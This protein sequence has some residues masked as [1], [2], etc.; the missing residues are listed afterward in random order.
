MERKNHPLTEFSRIED[1]V[2][3]TLDRALSGSFFSDRLNQ[4]KIEK[5][6]PTCDIIDQGNYL[7]LRAE[8]P[9][10]KKENLKISV[11]ETSISLKGELLQN[12]ETEGEIYYRSERT[13]GSFSR[14][15]DLPIEVNP[16]Q[17]DAALNE[18]ILEVKLPKKKSSKAKKVEIEI[19]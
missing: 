18:G 13:Y 12:K 1:V 4:C 15:I 6:I 11:D 17:V 10:L 3:Q 2:N 7:L 14:I 19:K 9:G 8:V 5:I 16:D